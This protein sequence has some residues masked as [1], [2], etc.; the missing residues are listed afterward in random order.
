MTRAIRKCSMLSRI[1]FA[2][3]LVASPCLAAGILDNR[4]AF[5]EANEPPKRPAV[6]EELRPMSA[7]LHAPGLRIDL[8]IVCQRTAIR[9][10][11]ACWSMGMSRD[12]NFMGLASHARQLK[13]GR[14]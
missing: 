12:L 9:P 5:S 3:A 13:G 7:G 4:P 14:R 2:L 6:C 1:V 11:G 8:A 10:N